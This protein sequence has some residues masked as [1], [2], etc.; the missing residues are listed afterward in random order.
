M[1]FK[2]YVIDQHSY[3]ITFRNGVSKD[4]K[5]KGFLIS[6]GNNKSINIY[7]F[8]SEYV[9]PIT[10]FPFEYLYSAHIINSYNILNE[11]LVLHKNK[12]GK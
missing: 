3:P 4:F 12:Y 9:F 2:K 8:H 10:H 11:E 1:Q 7:Y 6:F 5:Y